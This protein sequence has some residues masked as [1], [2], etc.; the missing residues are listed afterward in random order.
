MKARFLTG[1]F[2]LAFCS[3]QLLAKDLTKMKIVITGPNGKPVERADVIVRFGGR[4]I[5][6]LGA[7]AVTQWEMRS[8]QLGEADIPEMPKGSIRVQVIAKGFQ[9]F[10]E[11]FDVT[12][13]ERT[14]QIALQPP[15][16]QYSAHEQ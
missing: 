9:T 11:T 1:I 14:I 2:V 8:T 4:T 3:L 7:K 13:D 6:K 12:E 5:K 10:G 15:Q 16:K